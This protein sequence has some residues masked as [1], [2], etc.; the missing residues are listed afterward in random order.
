MV[1]FLHDSAPSHMENPVYVTLETFSWEVLPHAAYSPD[2]ASSG[3][4]LFAL[5][6]H[7]LV[8]QSFCSYKDIKKKWLDEWSVAKGKILL[9][10]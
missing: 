7:A 6:G 3:Y 5:M 8:E 1:I 10:W 2:L 4:H 9:A